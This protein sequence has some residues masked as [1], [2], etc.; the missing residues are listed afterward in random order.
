M[1]AGVPPDLEELGPEHAERWQRVRQDVRTDFADML[2]VAAQDGGEY[3]DHV[4]ALE[5]RGRNAT[6]LHGQ[7]AGR[8]SSEMRSLLRS[9]VRDG[10]LEDHRFG[11][12]NG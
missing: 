8:L 1:A 5:I 10:L 4:L 3:I 12:R 9:M 7:T 11:P 2:R 6:G